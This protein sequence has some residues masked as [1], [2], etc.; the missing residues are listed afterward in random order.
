MFFKYLYE[1]KSI[2][3]TSKW[4]R[5]DTLR[6]LLDEEEDNYLRPILGDSLME[7]LVSDYN[8]MSES[9]A[10]WFDNPDL[11]KE[12]VRIIRSCQRVAFYMMLANNS[13]LFSVSFNAGG[14]MN[15]MSADDYDQPSSDAVKRFERDAWKKAHR[16]IDS[17]LRLLEQDARKADSLYAELW[18]ES[19]YFYRQANL[20]FTTASEM[21][22]YLNIGDSRERFINLIPDIAYAQNVYIRPRIGEPLFNYIVSLK[23]N[24]P[25]TVPDASPSG[26]TT[27]PDASPSGILTSFIDKVL[28]ATALY[29]EASQKDLRRDDSLNRADMQIAL[30]CRIIKENPDYFISLIGNP[31]AADLTTVL[32]G[33]PIEG[34]TPT[35][36]PEASPSGSLTPQPPTHAYDP[37]DPHNAVFAPFFPGLRRY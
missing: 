26:S 24:P 23:Y 32:R 4:D 27:V 20:L 34:L 6:S 28:S 5:L 37:H 17:L 8:E 16:N 36:V 7:R 13:G 3:P 30:A 9:A 29:V 12:Q 2:I 21:H 18:K 22:E 1:I 15:A 25:A 11:D 35:T 19:D 14:G 31:P 33:I 10:I